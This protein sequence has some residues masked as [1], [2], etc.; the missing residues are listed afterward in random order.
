MNNCNTNINLI[1]FFGYRFWWVL[2]ERPIKNLSLNL[3]A[4]SIHFPGDKTNIGTPQHTPVLLGD[5]YLCN[6]VSGTSA[7]VKYICAENIEAVQSS[8]ARGGHNMAA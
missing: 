8:R 4:F 3:K 7:T 5:S 6:G 1:T 2:Y